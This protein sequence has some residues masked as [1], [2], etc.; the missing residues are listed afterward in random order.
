MVD[1]V[2][3]TNAVVADRARGGERS[4]LVVVAE[5]QTAGRGRLDRSWETP[6]R[7]G[8]T[9]SVLVRPAATVDQWT[10]LPLVAGYAAGWVLREHDVD[11]RLKW[12]NDV[13]VGDRKIGGILTEFVPGPTPGVVVGV[14][15]NVTT[16]REELP[17]PEATSVQ[18]ET[19]AAVDRTDLLAAY[20]RTFE[21]V[22]S[23]WELNPDGFAD[24][25]AQVCTTI[26]SRVRVDLP[27]GD[28]VT[29][30]ATG[31]GDHGM[32]LLDTAEG[33]TSVAA[34]DVVHLRGAGTEG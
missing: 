23:E 11:A 29:G 1:R 13:T 9:F 30:T 14:G 21:R 12:P 17:V 24:D 8:L 7:A 18:L 31:V 27:G 2:E 34:G 4:G 26:G 5:E 16:T 6:P 32:L 19:G 15:L 10:W 20:L 3:S 33:P 28:Q 22:L 25:Y